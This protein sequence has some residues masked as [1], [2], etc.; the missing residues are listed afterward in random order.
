M[1]GGQA[2]GGGVTGMSVGEGVALM[3]GVAI[4]AAGYVW[5]FNRKRTPTERKRSSPAISA[6]PTPTPTPKQVKVCKSCGKTE[7]GD[8]TLVRYHFQIS[9]NLR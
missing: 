6:A 1:E 5:W 2:R 8:R 4:A 7:S 3:A 9:W